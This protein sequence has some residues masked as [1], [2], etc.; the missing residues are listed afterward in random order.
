MYYDSA[1]DSASNW[2][3]DL[4]HQNLLGQS[5]S[6]GHSC[7]GLGFP[8]SSYHKSQNAKCHAYIYIDHCFLQF[9]GFDTAALS[10]FFLLF[11]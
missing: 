6:N 9:Q 11:Y 2:S 10:C 1:D 3:S 5:S 8:S 4:Y 7:S